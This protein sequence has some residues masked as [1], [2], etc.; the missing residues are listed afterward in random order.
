MNLRLYLPVSLCSAVAEDHTGKR[1]NQKSARSD[2]RCKTPSNPHWQTCT[3]ALYAWFF[4]APMRTPRTT[5]YRF[6]G[7]QCKVWRNR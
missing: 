4:H 1:S 3:V 6:H 7:R 5:L 2:D